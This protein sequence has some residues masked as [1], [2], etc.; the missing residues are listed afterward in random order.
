MRARTIRPTR[1]LQRL[2]SN[3]E[4]VHLLAKGLVAFYD[5]LM[6]YLA[7]GIEGSEV[8]KIFAEFMKAMGDEIL[9]Q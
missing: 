7:I 8:R 6:V 2:V 5:G 9:R 1:R 3:S 4:D